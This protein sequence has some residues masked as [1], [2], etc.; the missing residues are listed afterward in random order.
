MLMRGRLTIASNLLILTFFASTMV[1]AETIGLTT[2]SGWSGNYATVQR[3]IL[4]AGNIG[5]TVTLRDSTIVKTETTNAN[6]ST[7]PVA[8]GGASGWTASRY[9]VLKGVVDSSISNGGSETYSWRSVGAYRDEIFFQTGNGQPAELRLT[10]NV[11]ATGSTYDVAPIDLPWDPGG[12]Y[13]S[14]YS[15]LWI[16]WSYPTAGSQYAQTW[17]ETFG[18]NQSLNYDGSVTLSTRLAGYVGPPE[19]EAAYQDGYDINSGT[20]LP[21]SLMVSGTVKYG[22]L[23]WANTAEF[24]EFTAY[25]NGHQLNRNEFGINGDWGAPVP[26]PEPETYAMLLAG[27]GLLGFM[28]RRRKQKEAA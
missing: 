2:P 14:P 21:F 13:Y 4:D 25:Q 3:S 6:F 17:I 12:A 18:R 11:K 27:L 8:T 26:V 15:S 22:S 19:Y 24:V 23:D 20:Y 28:A 16:V 7:F 10:L 5:P 9:Q 1:L